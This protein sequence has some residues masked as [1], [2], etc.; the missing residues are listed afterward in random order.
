MARRVRWYRCRRSS[1]SATLL[2]EANWW[3]PRWLRWLPQLAV[4]K[5]PT[6]PPAVAYT[7]QRKPRSTSVRSSVGYY[8]VT[9]WQRTAVATAYLGLVLLLVVAMNATHVPNNF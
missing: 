1:R 5:Q 8:R 3:L 7:P 4:E 2:G 6:S 9:G